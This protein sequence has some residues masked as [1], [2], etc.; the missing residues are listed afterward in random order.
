M[1]FLEK[2]TNTEIL[3]L[4]LMMDISDK[5]KILRNVSQGRKKI[6]IDEL[7]YIHYFKKSERYKVRNKFIKL[8][9]E[10]LNVK[11]YL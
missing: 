8:L 11:E 10:L 1:K 9:K 7:S 6:I 4:I 5:K 3:T 2:M